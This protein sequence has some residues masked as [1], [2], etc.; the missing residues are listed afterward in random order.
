MNFVAPFAFA[1]SLEIGR[2]GLG[3]K[4]DYK[5]I[6]RPLHRAHPFRGPRPISPDYFHRYIQSRNPPSASANSPYTYTSTYTS[7]LMASVLDW[8]VQ[9]SEEVVYLKQDGEPDLKLIYWSRPGDTVDTETK[10]IAYWQ[11]GLGEHAGRYRHVASC[12][13]DRCPNLQAFATADMR[14]HGGS[15]GP[16]GAIS[17][18]EEL[19]N[20][21][22]TRILP[23]I[24]EKGASDHVRLLLLGHSLGGLV[25]T[26]VANNPQVLAKGTVCGLFL[27]APAIEPVVHGVVNNALAP[28]VGVVAAIPGMRK[29]TKTNDIDGAVISH[30]AK[31]VQK[32]NHDDKEL[33]TQISFGLAESTLNRGKKL[34]KEVEEK[35]SENS[36][37]CSNVP[38]LIVH[39]EL[40]NLTRPEGSQ[41]L[42]KAIANEVEIVIAP[43]AYHEVH[44]ET[45]EH[46]RKVFYDKLTDFVTRV[47]PEQ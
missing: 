31:I 1:R 30:D 9:L 46:G 16:R 42:A 45:L 27:S 23:S 5:F 18:T 19:E 40:D 20:D 37:L 43:G 32:Y 14:G 8:K 33:C 28:L 22:T 29:V 41:K 35:S 7:S 13:L 11:P 36:L 34:L 26:S 4:G 38:V 3:K 2:I 15:G 44:N 12:L 6:C 24:I 39:G 10:R 17:S 21:V 25:L 47:L